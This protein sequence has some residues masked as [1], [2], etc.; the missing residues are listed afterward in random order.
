MVGPQT[1]THV[2]TPVAPHTD[3]LRS[4]TVDARTVEVWD[5]SLYLCGWTISNYLVTVRSWKGFMSLRKARPSFSSASLSMACNCYWPWT[6]GPSERLRFTYCLRNGRVS[7]PPRARSLHVAC[8]HIGNID[9]HHLTVSF[10]GVVELGGHSMWASDPTCLF[11]V[12]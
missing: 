3:S 7:P 4:P 1:T 9:E 6:Y 8:H 11:E 10:D 2:H 5:E 12:L